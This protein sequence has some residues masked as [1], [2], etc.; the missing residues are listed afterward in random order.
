MNV[1]ALVPL[2]GSLAEIADL[3][4]VTKSAVTRWRQG[5]HSVSPLYQERLLKAARKRR[6]DTDFVAACLDVPRCPHCKRYHV[7]YC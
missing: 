7:V 6:M 4:G 3:A 1:D 5:R 2:F